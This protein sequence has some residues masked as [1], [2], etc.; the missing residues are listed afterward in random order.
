MQPTA[1]HFMVILP[2]DA[3][4]EAILAIVHR[5]V[6]ALAARD[7]VGATAVLTPAGNERDWPPSLVEEVISAYEAPGGLSPSR[8][9]SPTSAM[10]EPGGG[11]PRSEV[12]R[13]PERRARREVVGTVEYDLPLNGIWSDLTAIF[14]LRRLADG[15]ALEL[16]DIHIL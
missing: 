13:W 2:L 12:T 6:D 11:A 5:W 7:Y 9:T 14:W 1:R 16:Y 10:Q 4:D 8:V 15:L 3:S